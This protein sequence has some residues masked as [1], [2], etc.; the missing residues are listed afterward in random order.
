MYTIRVFYG[1]HRH[2]LDAKNRFRI[3]TKFRKFFGDK[4]FL[5]RGS[6]NCIYVFGEDGLDKLLFDRFKD[7]G[8]I[9]TKSII[10]AKRQIAGHT[11]EAEDDGQGRF[12]LPEFLIK[13]AK[14][15]KNIVSVG[16]SNWLEIWSEERWDEYNEENDDYDALIESLV[17]GD[18]KATV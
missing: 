5:T 2:Q 9:S 1:Q 8:L 7:I 12:T 11:A 17:M 3:P 6:D 10:K 13:H 15:S 16:S 14:I 18:E 4:I